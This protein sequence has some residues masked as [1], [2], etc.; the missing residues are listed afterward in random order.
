MTQAQEQQVL[1]EWKQSVENF[2][3]SDIRGCLDRDILEVGL[4]ILTLVGIDC[5]GGYFTGKQSEQETFR[6]FISSKYFPLEYQNVAGELYVLRNGLVHDYTTKH[7]R[8]VF[9]R[10]SGEGDPQLQSFDTDQGQAVA[11][12][13]EVLA[14][15]FL[16]AWELFSDDVH[17]DQAL[18][19]KVI[20]R[21]KQA[22]RGF[23]IVR[24][25]APKLLVDM[26]LRDGDV[27][28]GGDSQTY[29]GGTVGWSGS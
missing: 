13:R 6:E 26:P 4:I 27:Q 17:T 12:N 19:A 23:L 28:Q 8:F 21:I 9:F 24:D 25:F 7:N 10:R 2:V 11:L 15:D 29:S 5:L 16:R 14:R 3:V 22:G 1:Q 18:A 20:K